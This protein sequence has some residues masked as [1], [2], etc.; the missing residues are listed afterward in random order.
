MQALRYAQNEPGLIMVS[1]LLMLAVAQVCLPLKLHIR[2]Q[3]GSH[4]WCL[5]LLSKR[6]TAIIEA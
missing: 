2:W 3:R 4:H 1:E 5:L 6:R